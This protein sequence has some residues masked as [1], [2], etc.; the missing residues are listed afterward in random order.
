MKKLSD[1]ENS[2]NYNCNFTYPPGNPPYKY[3][4][5]E[6]CVIQHNQFIQGKDKFPDF[7]LNKFTFNKYFHSPHILKAGEVVLWSPSYIHV[8]V[9]SGVSNR[10]GEC[11]IQTKDGRFEGVSP[12]FL[13]WMEHFFLLRLLT[14]RL[15]ATCTQARMRN[16]SADQASKWIIQ[17]G[18]SVVYR[19]YK[20]NNK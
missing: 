3:T 13:L 7:E 12:E 20:I 8:L 14:I 5:L 2:I 18:H 17:E 1:I 19:D 4:G 9:V 6:I 15:N 10:N 11:K 16:N